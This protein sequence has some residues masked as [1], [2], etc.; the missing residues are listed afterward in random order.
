MSPKIGD[1]VRLIQPEIRGIIIDRRFDAEDNLEVKLR[2]E[3]GGESVE[4][5]IDADRVEGVAK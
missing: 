2:W 1:E 5:W 3:E 4:R